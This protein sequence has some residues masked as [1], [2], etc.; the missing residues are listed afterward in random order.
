[1]VK[2]ASGVAEGEKVAL[3][4]GIDLSDGDIVQPIEWNSK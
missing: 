3:N 2:L 4:A 1:M